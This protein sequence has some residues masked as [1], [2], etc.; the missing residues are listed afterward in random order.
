ANQNIQDHK[1][2]IDELKTNQGHMWGLFDAVANNAAKANNNAANVAK[3]DAKTDK[4]LENDQNLMTGLN[5]LA[6]ETAN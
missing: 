4:M 2:S 3:L 6:A 1:K 5:N